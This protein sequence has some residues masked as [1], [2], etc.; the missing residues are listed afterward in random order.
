[1]KKTK[2]PSIAPLGDRVLVK[3]TKDEGEKKLP[4]G[5]IIPETVDRE[6]SDQ[7][8]V[9]AVGSGRLSDEGK[10]IPVRVKKGDRVIFQW[11]EKVKFGGE[12]Y[13]LVSESNILAVIG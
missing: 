12:E 6:K 2:G 7:G 10:L 9:I 5:I 11:G 1:M 8:V 13:F 4:S 3:P